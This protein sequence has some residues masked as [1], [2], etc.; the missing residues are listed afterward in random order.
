[1][2]LSMP[3]TMSRRSGDSE[4]YMF[5]LCFAFRLVNPCGHAL[6][7]ECDSSKPERHTLWRAVGFTVIPAFDVYWSRCKSVFV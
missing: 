5:L 6:R 1:M 7:G 3:D 2:L 4:D